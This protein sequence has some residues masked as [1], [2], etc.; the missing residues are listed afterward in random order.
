MQRKMMGM[1]IY[2]A[3]LLLNPLL[4]ASGGLLIAQ[5]KRALAIWAACWLIKVALDGGSARQLLKKRF[6]W[7]SL[8]VVPIKDLLV[9][10]AWFC[11]LVSNKVNW[12]GNQLRVLKGT[13]LVP[14]N[15]PT[16]EAANVIAVEV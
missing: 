8:W 4:F 6:A 3:E 11:G 14:A 1:P 7:R 12:R 5:S 15:S 10:A 9:A 2:L 16:G 13:T